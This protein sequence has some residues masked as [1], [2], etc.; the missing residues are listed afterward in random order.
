MTFDDD[1]TAR[2]AAV[3]AEIA[4]ACKRCGR[5]V[6]DVTLVAASKMQPPAA[7]RAAWNAGVRD[8]GENYANELRDKQAVL[9]DLDIR[10]HFIGRVQASNA[11]LIARTQLVHGVGSW[12]QLQALAKV[13]SSSSPLPVLLQ[14]NLVG[15]D[16]KN[17]F[18]ATDVRD[19]DARAANL[20]VVVRG[21]MAMPLVDDDALPGAFSAVTALRDEVGGARWPIISMGMSNDFPLAIAVGAT[22]VRIGT[23][24]F[25][26]RGAA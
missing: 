11:K 26:P 18:N 8:F 12:S 19:V 24:L 22:H 10:W 15:E 4:E 3:R 9:G 20:A 2:V 25:G 5:S 14:V 16:T 23:R 7:I 13:S 1:I 21:L 6:D 17:G